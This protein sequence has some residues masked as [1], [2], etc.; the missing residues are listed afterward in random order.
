MIT[1]YKSIFAGVLIGMAAIISVN[2]TYPHIIFAVG[3]ISVVCCGG[4]LYTGMIGKLTYRDYKQIIQILIGNIIGIEI[5][6]LYVKYFSN[7]DAWS[8]IITNKESYS[9]LYVF[10]SSILCGIL[11]CVATVLN[12]KSNVLIMIVCISAFILGGFPHCI[13]DTFYLSLNGISIRDILYMLISIVGNTVGAK[14]AYLCA[15]GNK[16]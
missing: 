9:L 12:T 7:I 6:C 5:I 11:M 15:G 3:L 16:V 14:M 13:A 2:A 10:V 8:Q 1:L 4:Y